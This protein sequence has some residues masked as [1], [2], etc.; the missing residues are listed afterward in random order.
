MRFIT[1][2]ILAVAFIGCRTGGD[3]EVDHWNECLDC[4]NERLWCEELCLNG[5]EICDYV[6][7]VCDEERIHCLLECEEEYNNCYGRE[8]CWDL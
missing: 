3:D 8:S 1:Y 5:F 4:S 6:F 7:E 2:F